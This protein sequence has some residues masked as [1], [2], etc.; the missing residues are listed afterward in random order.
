MPITL[1]VA[2]FRSWLLDSSVLRSL[3]PV[4]SDATQLNSTSSWVELSCVTID[5]LTDATQLSPTIG[6]ATDPVEQRTVTTFRTDRWHAV[7]HAV[8]VSTT[9]RRVELCRYKRALTQSLDVLRTTSRINILSY[10]LHVNNKRDVSI[11]VC[12]N[13]CNKLRWKADNTCI[14]FIIVVSSRKTFSQERRQVSPGLK[15][16]CQS[17]VEKPRGVLAYSNPWLLE[18]RH[19][20]EVSLKS[21]PQKL[22]FCL[23]MVFSL[24]RNVLWLV[25]MKCHLWHLLPQRPKYLN[26]HQSQEH[27]R[28]KMH[29]MYPRKSSP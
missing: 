19:R 15:D 14:I 12:S 23:E 17:R 16:W 20:T 24:L 1:F 8:N 29:S 11:Y 7:V 13:I 5:T 27:N 4:Y 25:C 18:P 3:R 2:P 10:F 21:R 22:K 6:N 9:R 26:L 28:A